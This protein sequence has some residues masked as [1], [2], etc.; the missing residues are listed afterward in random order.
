MRKGN[1]AKYLG[2]P[3][4]CGYHYD[5][6]VNDPWMRFAAEIVI[7]AVEDWRWLIKQEAWYDEQQWKPFYSNGS[8][9]FGE[10]RSFFT[11]EWCEFLMQ[12]FDMKPESILKLLEAELQEAMQQPSRK[13]NRKGGQK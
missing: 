10:L 9:S 1:M 5:T 13:N 4:N 11:S 7:H 8:C 3:L 12:G 6:A 2:K